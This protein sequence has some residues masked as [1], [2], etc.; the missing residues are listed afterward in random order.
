MVGVPA[1]VNIYKPA[2]AKLGWQMYATA[3]HFPE[4]QVLTASSEPETVSLGNF[5][6]RLRPEVD[7]RLPVT[8]RICNTRPEA[9]AVK[10][11]H[12][13]TDREEQHSC[14]GR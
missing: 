6:A 11:V 12:A 13:D 8:E 1:L 9:I 4:I 14:S 10:F 5:A 7:Y 2:P 3:T